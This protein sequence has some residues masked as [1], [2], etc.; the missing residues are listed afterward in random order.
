MDHDAFKTFIRLLPPA[1]RVLDAGCSGGG[2]Y[3][4]A[5]QSLNFEP[6]GFA[7]SETA[8]AT[9]RQISGGARVWFADLRR[10]SLK[11]ETY[12]AIWAHE[13]LGSLPPP[14]VQRTMVTFFAALKRGGILFVSL[15]EAD[16]AAESPEPTAGSESALATTA[17]AAEGGYRYEDFASLLRQSGFK[18]LSNGRSLDDSR[19]MGFLAQRI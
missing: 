11:K 16:K 15:R 18:I 19:R 5:L 14:G 10:L 4:Q 8:A 12:D 6:E 7:L 1:A 3:L 9:A 13:A 17:P 2:I